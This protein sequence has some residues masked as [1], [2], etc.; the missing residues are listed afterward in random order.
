M[1]GLTKHIVVETVNNTNDDRQNSGR[2]SR[3]FNQNI[4]KKKEKALNN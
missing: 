4:Q 1:A 3:C 2:V